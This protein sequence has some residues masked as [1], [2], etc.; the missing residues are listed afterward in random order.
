MRASGWL[1]S[2]LDEKDLVQLY[3]IKCQACYDGNVFEETGGKCA[4]RYWSHLIKY[5]SVQSEKEEALLKGWRFMFCFT[6][7]GMDCEFVQVS[8]AVCT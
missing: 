7:L 8:K 3:R 2:G 4:L 5:L 6:A 1:Q